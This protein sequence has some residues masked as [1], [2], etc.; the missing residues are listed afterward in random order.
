MSPTETIP[1][2]IPLTL[3]ELEQSTV[4]VAMLEA[5]RHTVCVFPEGTEW[6]PQVPHRPE[7]NGTP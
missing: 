1:L 4:L 7:F 5:G 2:S 3:K 6:P